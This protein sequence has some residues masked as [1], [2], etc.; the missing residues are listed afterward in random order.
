MRFDS[1]IDREFAGTYGGREL[2]S[3]RSDMPLFDDEFIA[4]M[5]ARR[6]PARRGSGGGSDSGGGRGRSR[7][8]SPAFSPGVPAGPRDFDDRVRRGHS[9]FEVPMAPVEP[10]PWGQ[11]RLAYRAKLDLETRGLVE[12]TREYSYLSGTGGRPPVEGCVL[13]LLSFFF[14][15]PFRSAALATTR[16]F[17][18]PNPPRSEAAKQHLQNDLTRLGRGPQAT[19]ADATATQFVDKPQSYADQLFE[20][21][22]AAREERILRREREGSVDNIAA[23]N[24]AERD[25]IVRSARADVKPDVV[26]KKGLVGKFGRVHDH[27]SCPCGKCVR[28]RAAPN[29]LDR[30]RNTNA[31]AANAGGAASARAH[32]GL[33]GDAVMISQRGMV[34]SSPASLSDP[35]GTTQAAGTLR[36]RGGG[37]GGLDL[38]TA[39]S[40]GGRSSEELERS[41][42]LERGPAVTKI[43]MRETEKHRGILHKL[44]LSGAQGWSEPEVAEGG[45][46]V[47]YRQF[48]NQDSTCYRG[49]CLVQLPADRVFHYLSRLE[50]DPQL[51]MGEVVQRIDRR[52]E[53]IHIA[54]DSGS[55]LASDR[56]FVVFES[57]HDS[58]GDGGSTF[59][60]DGGSTFGGGSSIGGSGSGS[61]GVYT[62]VYRSIDHRDRP[63]GSYTRGEIKFGGYVIVPAGSNPMH[64]VVIS[65]MQMAAGGWM[66]GTVG[67]NMSEAFVKKLAVAKRIMEK[68][69]E[70]APQLSKSGQRSLRP[71]VFQ[72]RRESA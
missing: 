61:G 28:R 71:S 43:Y 47:S 55:A 54:L 18:A 24:P 5:R 59:G 44:A 38:A 13:F 2:D 39:A 33:G 7:S 70:R 67:D 58:G 63:P 48:A 15:P 19:A 25:A 66:P 57:A 41:R 60:G 52:H 20:K 14:S 9:D 4:K 62:I 68:H 23:P 30:P 3:P 12:R 27:A 37:G 64:S 32:P 10:G 53:V 45:V 26:R 11:Y 29:P 16:A 35:G 22:R 42:N 51:L 50:Y 1:R 72:T 65:L 6:S 46:E 31:A 40:A 34:A 8:R 56:D 49:R 69:P 36:S 17:V 21:E